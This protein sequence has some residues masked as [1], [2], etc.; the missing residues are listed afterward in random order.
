MVDGTASEFSSG[1][2][3]VVAPRPARVA[4]NLNRVTELCWAVLPPALFLIAI[5]VAWDVLS[6][7]GVIPSYIIPS[8]GAIAHEFA[9]NSRVLLKHATATCLEAILGF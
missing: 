5:V 2:D 6:G 7:W 3:L 4:F 1:D 8:P 9:T